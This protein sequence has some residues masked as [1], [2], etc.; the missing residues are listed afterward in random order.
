MEEEVVGS[1]NEA[2]FIKNLTRKGFSPDKSI[3][4]L[5]GNAVDARRKEGEVVIFIARICPDH[6]VKLMDNGKGMTPED[7]R[8]MFDMYHPNHEKEETIGVS[9][10]GGKAALSCL[11]RDPS[12]AY[13]D[14]ILKTH[15]M[16]GSYHRVVIPWSLIHEKGIYNGVIR[17]NVMTDDEIDEFQ[18]E[19]KKM[20]FLDDIGTTIEFSSNTFLEEKILYWFFQSS[21]GKNIPLEERL[22]IVFGTVSSLEIGLW[23]LGATNPIFLELYDFFKGKPCEFLIEK[24]TFGVDVWTD[25]EGQA[26]FLWGDQEFSPFGRNGHRTKIQTVQES[27]QGWTFQG[28]IKME[29]AIRTNPPVFNPYKPF[30]SLPPEDFHMCGYDQWFFPPDYQDPESICD[31]MLVRN[32]QVI[33]TN[34]KIDGNKNQKARSSLEDRIKYSHVRCRL[35]YIVRSSQSNYLDRLMEIQENKTQHKGRLPVSLERLVRYLRD[36]YCNK[37]F[38]YME[39]CRQESGTTDTSGSDE[40]VSIKKSRT[41]THKSNKPIRFDNTKDLVLWMNA[42]ILIA[43]NMPEN[44]KFKISFHRL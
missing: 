23:K 29:A 37:I 20:G 9:G 32:H 13:T 33:S 44:S 40:A 4:E 17:V 34:I 22:D 25:Q 42:Q 15:T 24:E 16:N 36:Q 41:T 2:G 35:Q 27:K 39:D 38:Q 19:R 5:I 11:S 21:S 10:L 3:I 12:G 7:I 14:V 28:E 18:K 1:I 6:V 30:L 31:V 8:R 26:R 43:R